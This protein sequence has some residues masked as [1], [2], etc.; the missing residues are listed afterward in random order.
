METPEQFAELLT[1][2]YLYWSMPEPSRKYLDRQEMKT[3][4]IKVIN[5][6]LDTSLSLVIEQYD[7]KQISMKYMLYLRSTILNDLYHDIYDIFEF[8]KS[9]YMRCDI[10][11]FVTDSLLMIIRKRIHE[12]YLKEL[13][14]FRDSR[15]IILDYL[16]IR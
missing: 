8:I 13:N 10:D 1:T 6:F 3:D 14:I 12:N 11:N 5:N 7:S 4:L 15:I 2:D 16:K 9:K